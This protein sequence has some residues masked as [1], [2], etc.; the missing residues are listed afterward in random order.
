[1]RCEGRSSFY[2]WQ[3]RLGVL[4]SPGHAK[5]G[6]RRHTKASEL[7]MQDL[8]QYMHDMFERNS[9]VS[10]PLSDAHLDVTNQCVNV[11]MSENGVDVDTHDA[12]SIIA[13]IFGRTGAVEDIGVHDSLYRY[14]NHSYLTARVLDFLLQLQLQL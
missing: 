6:G 1:M 8:D 12:M 10:D 14:A 2:A 3:V 11:T 5:L 7:Y 13:Q 4:P 9:F